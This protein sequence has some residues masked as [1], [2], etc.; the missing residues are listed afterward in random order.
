MARFVEPGVQA[1]LV[2]AGGVLVHVTLGTLYTWG[3]LNAY[4]A[5]HM[6]MEA[7]GLGWVRMKDTGWVFSALFSGQGIGM[8]FGGAIEKRIGPRWATLFGCVVMSIGVSLGQLAISSY[9]A[10]VLTYG[11]INGL[12][13]GLAYTSPLVCALK[14]MPNKK[15]LISGIITA[16]FGAGALVFNPVQTMFVN[17]E[18]VRPDAAP[19]AETNPGEL[20]FSDKALLNRVPNLF[21]LLASCY[22]VVQLIGCAFLEN[23]PK[24]WASERLPLTQRGDTTTGTSLSRPPKEAVQERAFWLLFLMFF[25]NGLSIAFTATFWKGLAPTGVSDR[26]LSS[27]GSVASLCNAAGRVFWGA[28]CDRANFRLAVVCLSCIWVVV[29]STFALSST[30]PVALY[31]LWVCANFFSLGGNFALFPA[32]TAIC[33][34]REHLGTIYGLIFLSQLAGSQMMAFAAQNLFAVLGALGMTICMAACSAV[35]VGI[36]L[37]LPQLLPAYQG[38]FA[39]KGDTKK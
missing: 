6:R 31:A 12:G 3:N 8:P 26:L 39:T 38:L 4:V 24:E 19:Y 20:Y 1:W 29:M 22:L 5:S 2:L 21:T 35:T 28:A 25:L 18:D 9:P 13:I 30:L 33:F 23:P 32:A 7:E 10:F 16:G 37:A 34:G 36:G 15:G 11:F 14:W 27:I 17:P